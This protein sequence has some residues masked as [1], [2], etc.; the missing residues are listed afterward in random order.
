V[1]RHYGIRTQR[2]KLIH[3]YQVGE[4]ELF[5]LEKDRHELKNLYADA[6]H[7]GIVADLKRQ[8]DELRRQ[9]KDET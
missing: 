9:Y 4:W 5:D 7:A 3:Y 1:A 8:L 2:Y 6:E